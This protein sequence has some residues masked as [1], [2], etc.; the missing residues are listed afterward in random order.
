MAH[1]SGAPAGGRAVTGVRACA[2]VCFCFLAPV[3]ANGFHAMARIGGP[4]MLKHKYDAGLF[5]QRSLLHSER[6]V[7]G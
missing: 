5:G 4:E 2:I 7:F 6:W 1:I 3:F